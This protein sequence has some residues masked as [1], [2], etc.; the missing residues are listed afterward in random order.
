MIVYST[1]GNHS[2]KRAKYKQVRDKRKMV[3]VEVGLL[4]LIR[5][6]YS[7]CKPDIDLKNSFVEI[8]AVCSSKKVEEVVEVQ[9]LKYF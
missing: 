3:E 4:W 1:L 8:S 9:P 6:H 5:N 7:Y 2:L